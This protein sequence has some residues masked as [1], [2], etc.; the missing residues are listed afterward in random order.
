M[1]RVIINVDT[2]RSPELVNRKQFYVSISRA[3]LELTLYTDD[4][5]SLRAAVD[6]NR[7]KSVALDHFRSELNR[8]IKTVPD[9][10]LH[11][12]NRSYGIRR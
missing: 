5:E 11:K 1:D 2:T 6:R 4:R 9:H 7:E 3:R 12:L 10:E 8:A